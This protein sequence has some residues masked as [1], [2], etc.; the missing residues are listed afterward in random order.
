MGE[1]GQFCKVAGV[2][3]PKLYSILFQNIVLQYNKC[4]LAIHV[5]CPP[6]SQK[7]LK[8]KISKHNC[9]KYKTN[10][11]QPMAARYIQARSN[12]VVVI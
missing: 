1:E 9:Q 7:E 6:G 8:V 4:S 12:R 10:K 2:Q 3:D 11:G 5:T